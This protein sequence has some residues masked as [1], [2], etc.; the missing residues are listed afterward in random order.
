MRAIILAGGLFEQEDGI[1][2]SR[3]VGLQTVAGKPWI[4]HVIEVLV[5]GGADRVELIL[6]HQAY[7][8]ERLLGDGTRWGIEIEYHF[9][10]TM[11]KPLSCLRGLE[12]DGNS[13]LLS[14][15]AVPLDPLDPAEEVNLFSDE[16]ERWVASVLPWTE[17]QRLCTRD[18]GEL[19]QELSQDSQKGCRALFMRAPA[20]VLHLN[21][22]FLENGE[23]L[24]AVGREV[25]PG[26]WI[27]R[28]VL[29][30][31]T[32]RVVPPV[33]LGPHSRIGAGVEIGP[34]ASLGEHCFL[35]N[36]S[37][38]VNSVIQSGSFLGEDLELTD[39]LSDRD[40]IYQL[41]LAVRMPVVDADIAGRSR[42]SFG[43]LLYSVGQR[44]LALILLLLFAP[45]AV[46]RTLYRKVR[47]RHLVRV[48]HV[49]QPT[50]ND[51][52][53]WNLASRWRE[54]APDARS[55]KEHFWHDFLPGLP[56]AVR[57]AVAVVG[58][59]PRTERELEE[60]PSD[61]RARVLISQVGLVTEALA[62]HGVAANE[63]EQYLC[64]AYFAENRSMGRVLELLLRYLAGVLLEPPGRR[65]FVDPALAVSPEDD[66]HSR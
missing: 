12:R 66:S 14:E 41:P 19:L 27:G 15:S 34:F 3:A 46:G 59:K 44:F 30:H 18:W 13:I 65:H 35:G 49:A 32:A 39:S 16:G 51:P 23:G 40:S 6:W 1:G 43:L 8:Y 26:V 20:D 24:L 62:F 50:V 61:W 22:Y 28:N 63:D 42:D 7:R 60:L 2:D 58:S 5:N 29:L 53:A 55:L 45:L 31:P 36:R 54:D 57:G 64:E 21:R 52:M 9:A 56:Q 47:S 17:V 25:E 33:F 4:Q 37:K 10:H 11:E 48:E 38:V